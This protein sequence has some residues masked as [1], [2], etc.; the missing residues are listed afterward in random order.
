MNGGRWRRR[1]WWYS[2]R[3]RCSR[4]VATDRALSSTS[5]SSGD[6]PVPDTPVRLPWRWKVGF[7]LPR[8]LVAGVVIDALLRFAPVGWRPLA[9][10]EGAVRHRVLGEAY[11]RNLSNKFSVGYGDLAWMGNLRE[12]REYRSSSFTTDEHGFRASRWGPAAAAVVFGDSF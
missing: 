9:P 3:C 6:Q 11:A 4:S 5:S 12:L 8:M 7:L 2:S 10:G 1:D